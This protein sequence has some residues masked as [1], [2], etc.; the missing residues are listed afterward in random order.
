MAFNLPQYIIDAQFAQLIYAEKEAN[1]LALNGTFTTPQYSRILSVVRQAVQTRYNRQPADPTLV[2]TGEF[3]YA[4]SGNVNTTPNTVTAP[5]IF[6]VQPQSQVVTEN[7]NVSFSVVVAGGVSPYQYQ[8]YFNSNPIGGATNSTLTLSP[9]I[10]ASAGQ[11]VCKVTDS[12]GAII[13]SNPANLVVNQAAITGSFYYGST[14][15]FSA[16]SGGTDN[17]AYQGTFPITHNAPLSVPYP[18]AADNNMFLVIRVPI[19]ES[20]KSTW[21]NTPFNNGTIQPS[22]GIFRVPLQPAGLPLYTYYLTDLQVSSDFT[23][24]LILT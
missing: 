5:L 8:W 13:T 18:T 19:G 4:L 7:T 17:I 2:A 24:P 9:A 10:L 14:D 6:I 11:Y 15:Y 22:D 21:F 1:G 23:Q 3:M 12:V 20:L 16:L